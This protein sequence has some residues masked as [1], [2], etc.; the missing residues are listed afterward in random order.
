MVQCLVDSCSAGQEIPGYYGTR[1]FIAVL[2]RDLALSPVV[3]HLN[4]M[5]TLT[6]FSF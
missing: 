1:K 4:S 2:I 6:Q 5:H 3:N